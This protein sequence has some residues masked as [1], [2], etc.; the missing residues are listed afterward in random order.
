M[1]HSDVL[2]LLFPPAIVESS[3]GK[4]FSEKRGWSFEDGVSDWKAANGATI[5]QSSLYPY[6]GAKCMKVTSDGSSAWAQARSGELACVEGETLRIR[7][8]VYGV[9]SSKMS[10]QV[11]DLSHAAFTTIAETFLLG[12]FVLLEGNFTVP[13][14]CE[15]ARVYVRPNHGYAEPSETYWDCIQFNVGGVFGDDIE[16]EGKFLDAAQAR[17]EDLLKEMFPDTAYELLSR[18]EVICGV[19]P[20]AGDTLQLR[21]D[22]VEKRLR[23]IGSMSIPYF[24]SLASYSEVGYGE[25]GWGESGWGGAEGLSIRIEELHPFMAG[26]GRA[27][28]ELYVPEIIFCWRV[29][30]AG[31]QVYKFRA[32]TSCAGERLTSW[33]ADLA[34][35]NL[36]NEFKPAHTYIIF[37]YE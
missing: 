18:W 8:W 6:S 29:R 36:F 20:E 5:E 9:A 25:G 15:K 4:G 23:E 2:R 21:R 27:G 3:M 33:E 16:L 17:A 12:Q 34:L 30:V 24:L 14:G 26:W 10:L 31:R 7:V 11:Y 28:D 37:D 22:R 32:G 1:S 19:Y 13:A 35:E